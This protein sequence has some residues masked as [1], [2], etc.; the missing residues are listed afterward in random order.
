MGGGLPEGDLVEGAR[1]KGRERAASARAPRAPRTS[2]RAEAR[3][4]ARFRRARAGRLSA[5]PPVAEPRADLPSVRAGGRG[6]AGERRAAR[7]GVGAPRR[8]VDGGRGG[9]LDGDAGDLRGV[10]VGEARTGRGGRDD[11]R[12]RG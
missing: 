10:M 9:R 5:P 8:R 1:L 3:L 6:R 12:G 4:R 11:W 7:R 2:G